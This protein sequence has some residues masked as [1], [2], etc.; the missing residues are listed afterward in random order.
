MENA[1]WW[2]MG[3]NDASQV[4]ERDVRMRI[5]MPLIRRE[6]K[7]FESHICVGG[8]GRVRVVEVDQSQLEAELGCFRT[9]F[10]LLPGLIDCIQLI[11]VLRAVFEVLVV[12]GFVIGSVS[13]V[14]L[15]RERERG[16]GTRNPKVVLL[17]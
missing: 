11:H 14:I 7:V 2:F 6:S 1:V 8:V 10:C 3:K 12:L 5:A 17:N 13:Q 16:G 4:E 9:Q 15:L